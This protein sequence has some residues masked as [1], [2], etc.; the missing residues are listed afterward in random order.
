MT[1]TIKYGTFEKNIDVSEIALKKCI[2]HNILHIPSGD[3]RRANI[4]TD[5]IYGVLKSIIINDDLNNT[6]CYSSNKDIYIDLE[7]KKIYV[8][9]IPDYIKLIFPNHLQK[10]SEIH[11]KLKMD[12]GSLDEE[13]PEQLMSATYLTGTE[14]VLEIGANVGRNSLVI[15][16]ILNS[17]SNN[18]FV[19]L[20]CD[21]NTVILLT[22][23]K[24][25][26]NLDFKI[27]ASAL[28]KRKLIQRGWDTIC[29]DVLLPGYT[30]VNTITVEEL[31][32]K[33]NIV[34]DTLVLDCEGAF[35]YILIDMP[36]ILNNI[37]LIIMENDY[38]DYSHKTYIDT[39]LKNNNFYVDY[40]REGGW[41]PCKSHFFEVWKRNL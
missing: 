32:Q 24:D 34:F 19:S 2:K 3:T 40:T 17:C 29:S 10:L 15:S 5:P 9:N 12:N 33:Y 4:F 14:K 41:G 11:K 30:N 36:E 16:Y 8:D 38:H 27:E 18:N 20:E 39:V 37:N 13:F 7:Q 1:Y 22:K 23:N 25:I 28:S 26:N 21:K 35:Y 31:N 6:Y